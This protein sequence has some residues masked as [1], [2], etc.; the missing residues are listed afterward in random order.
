[1]KSLR[2]PKENLRLSQGNFFLVNPIRYKMRLSQV[3]FNC[4]VL[5]LFCFALP[6]GVL[7]GWRFIFSQ[8]PWYLTILEL[9]ITLIGLIFQMF[10]INFIHL[11]GKAITGGTDGTKE[12]HLDDPNY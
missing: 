3:G 6:Y 8:F 4:V 10:I 12:V 11:L 7:W 1:M 2:R 9:A 5:L